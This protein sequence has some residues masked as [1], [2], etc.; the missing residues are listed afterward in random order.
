M[1]A[2]YGRQLIGTFHERFGEHRRQVAE[3]DADPGQADLG[4]T[5]P[6]QASHRAWG[7]LIAFGGQDDGHSQGIYGG[8]TEFDY[9]FG[10]LQTGFDLYARE[11]QDGQRDIAGVYLALGHGRGEV[12]HSLLTRTHDAGHDS[13]DA[14]SLGGYCTS[15]V[16]GGASGR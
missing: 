12:E 16:V 4:H 14:V 3:G 6:G 2:I 11:H 9:T 10:A 1:A 13:F 15:V 5:D 8:T 7:R